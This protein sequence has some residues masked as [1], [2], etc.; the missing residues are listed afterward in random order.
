MDLPYEPGSEIRV[1][2]YYRATD[3][4][5]LKLC[6]LSAEAFIHRFLQHVLPKGFVKVCYFGFF[7]PGCRQRMAALS[8]QLEQKYPE[9]IGESEAITE[10][11]DPTPQPKLCCPSC[12]QPMLFQ[13][14]IQPTGGCPP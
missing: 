2:V 13:K 9:N 14:A 12:G 11:A 8:Q 5:Q 10:L 6:T 3:T 7:A 1:T 4:G